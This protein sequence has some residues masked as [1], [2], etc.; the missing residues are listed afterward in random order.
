V[1]AIAVA[2]ILPVAGTVAVLLA[3]CLLRA[4]DRTRSGLA[5]RR[6]MRGAR[7]ADPLVAAATTP[8]AIA[9]SLLV[10]LV[11]APFGLLIA[12][13]AAVVAII[14]T[15]GSH[16]ALIAAYAAGLFAAISCAGPGS[17]APR[18]QLNRVFNVVARSRLSAATLTVVFGCL[19]AAMVSLTLIQSPL[20]WP[21][22]DPASL[23][24]QLPGVHLPKVHVPKVHVPSVHL[25]KVHLPKVHLPSVHGIVHGGLSR[26]ANVG[27]ELAKLV[28]L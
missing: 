6:Q 2:V 23:L 16:L 7:R 11:V 18:R 8:W 21:A 13:G 17:R 28:R 10:T 25:P 14:V 26:L 9:H 15:R 5:A 20:L 4:G 12:G 27:H 22:P 3:I 24:S 19:A 1:A